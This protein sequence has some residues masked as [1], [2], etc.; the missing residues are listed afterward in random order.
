[1]VDST[2]NASVGLE[3]APG[4]ID[5]SGP[6]A[7][8]SHDRR[9]RFERLCAPLRD[10]LYRFAAWLTRDRSLAE[11]IVQETLLR[12]WSSLDA[13][14]DERAVR[15]W[16]LKIVRRETAR[17]YERNRHPTTSIDDLIDTNDPALAAPESPDVADVRRAIF[18]LDDEYREPLVLQVLMG[19]TTAEI[20]EITRIN[21]A[22]V[23]TRLYRAR[24]RLRADLGLRLD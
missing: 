5:G 4:A 23:L 22:T 17:V 24:H 14:Q 16:L 9:R 10:D 1:M 11:D 20:A 8:S 19:F 15:P 21:P 6:G 18:A 7:A 2:R 3:P 12:A 13:L